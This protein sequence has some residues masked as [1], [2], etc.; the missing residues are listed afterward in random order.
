MNN[1][2]IGGAERVLLD[3]ISRLSEQHDIHVVSVLGGGPLQSEFENVAQVYV[4]G[5]IP[6]GGFLGKLLWVFSSPITA[7]RL[8]MFLKR[9]RPDAVMS[10]LFAADVLGMTVARMAGVR[11]RVL[12]QHDV[13]AFGWFKNLLKRRFGLGAATNIVAVSEA[14]RDFLQVTWGQPRTKITVIENGVDIEQLQ[15]GRRQQ[16]DEV[17]L[18]FLGRLEPVK[19]PQYFLDALVNLSQKNINPRVLVFGSGSLEPRLQQF[20]QEKGLTNVT[21]EGVAGDVPAAL[22]VVDVLVVPSEE[23]GFGLV[24]TEALF[25]G[26]VVVASD[27]PAFHGLV[28][29]GENGLLFEA[30]SSESLATTLEDLLTD[31]KL[32]HALQRG[33]D[34]WADANKDTF[35]ISS[36]AQEYEKALGL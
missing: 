18:G 28:N 16:G 31:E 29:G 20:V 22:R 32:L 17:V 6:I 4:L 30:G 35:N 3:I 14:V 21:F 9:E 13:H 27:L 2:A 1:F 7:A 8:L 36:K 10:S 26:K 15:E 19:G 23:E 12:V 33:V 5:S 24:V 25:A 34:Q 11:R